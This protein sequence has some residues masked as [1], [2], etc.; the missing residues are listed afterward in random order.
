MLSTKVLMR[1]GVRLIPYSSAHDEQTVVWLNDP[2]VKKGFGLTRAVSLEGHRNWLLHANNLA[3]W[4]I[5][6]DVGDHSGNMLLHLEPN[7]SSAYLQL[8]IGSSQARG[9]GL[10]KNALLCALE[11]AFEHQGLNRV[12]L[13]VFPENQAAISLYTKMGF[14]QEGTEREAVLRDGTFEDQYR[15]SLLKAEWQVMRTECGL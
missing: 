9:R 11:W 5:L 1:D 4:A 12:W 6:D 10:G 13:H 7:R 14:I 2:H 3:I 15:Y 8:Y